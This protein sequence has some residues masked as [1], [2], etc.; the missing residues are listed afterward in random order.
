MVLRVIGWLLLLAA[1]IAVGWDVFHWVH[2]GHWAATPTGKAW[3]QASPGSLNL[4]QAVIER[5]IWKTLWNPIIL[6]VLLQPIWLV[7]GI[8]GLLLALLAR[9]RRRRRFGRS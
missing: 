7:L 4:M 6:T 9:S 2:E 5:H 3:Y 8:P 1:L